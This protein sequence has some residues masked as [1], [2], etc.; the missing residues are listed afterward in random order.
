LAGVR[1][2]I[3]FKINSPSLITRLINE[4]LLSPVSESTK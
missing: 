3:H 4:P 1:F 2:L